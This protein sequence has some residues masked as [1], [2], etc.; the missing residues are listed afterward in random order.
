MQA[1]LNIQRQITQDLTVKAGY[2]G[3]RG[4]HL[5]IRGDDGNMTIPT[6]TSSGYLFPCG[7]PQVAGRCTAGNT[8]TGVSA[9]VN[10]VLGILRYIYWGTDSSYNA[11]YVNVQK[12]LSHQLPGSSSLPLGEVNRTTT[13]RTIAGDTFANGL[14]SLF[15]FAPRA[16][17]GL[18]DFN[19]GQSWIINGLWDIP[20]SKSLGGFG[21][22][23]LGG[24]EVGSIFRIIMELRLLR[25]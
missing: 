16:L 5:L 22:A 14:N 8:D 7:P 9:Q 10:P 2:V 23:A 17:R 12:R 11:M 21:N 24:W 1:N 18:S 13:R 3:S 4:V 25:Y 20:N 6:L 15:W 19:V